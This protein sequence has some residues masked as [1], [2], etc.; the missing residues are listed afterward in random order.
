[1]TDAARLSRMLWHAREL[2]DMYADIVEAEIGKPE[3]SSR[4]LIAEIDEYRAEHGWSP[5]GFGGEE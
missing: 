1:M 3:K 5:H 4:K 2:I